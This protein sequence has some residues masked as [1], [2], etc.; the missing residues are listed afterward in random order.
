MKILVRT[1]RCLNTRG[2]SKTAS[3]GVIFVPINT[4]APVVPHKLRL[5]EK[6]KIALSRY[7]SHVNTLP[8][9]TVI[10][11]SYKHQLFVN[12]RFNSKPC[13]SIIDNS[14]IALIPKMSN[15][16]LLLSSAHVRVVCGV[17][18]NLVPF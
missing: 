8:R 9:S 12:S 11:D 5:Y 18:D 17:N 14:P 6:L 13:S 1:Q 4:L 16:V 2:G 15:K 3:I 10:C 7:A